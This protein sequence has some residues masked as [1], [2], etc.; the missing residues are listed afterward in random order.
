MALIQLAWRARQSLER[1]A[2]SAARARAVRRA[3]A[4]LWLHAGERV[5]SVARRLGLSRRT[6][7]KIV[8]RYRARTG[9]PVAQRV[10]DRPHSGRPATLRERV[11]RV[12]NTLLKRKPSR[13]GYRASVWSTPMLRRQVERR[14]HT[15]VSGRTVRR[16]LRGLRYRYKRPRYVLARRSPTWRQAKGGSKMA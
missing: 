6:I 4:L 8:E 5:G 7:Y 3:Q 10:V 16:A 9:E 1:I 2:H 13:Y 12:V 15:P 11:A 14:L